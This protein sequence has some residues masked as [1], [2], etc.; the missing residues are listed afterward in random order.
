[1][2]IYSELERLKRL[3]DEGVITRDEFER[4]KTRLLSMNY[5]AQP[6]I[7]RWD[8][9][10]DES[11]FVVLM[12]AS[13][14][15]SSF[16]A[17]L[18]MWLLYKKKSLLVDEAGKNILNFQISYAIYAIILFLTCIGTIFVIFIPIAEIIFII[19][20]TIKATNGESWKYPLS[21]NFIK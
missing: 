10:I 2:D 21:I 12:H 11:S 18:V 8:L 13:Q 19:I 5:A 6:A 7:P 9:G 15:I 20:A 14:F 16:L 4:E 3:L 17:P 1:M